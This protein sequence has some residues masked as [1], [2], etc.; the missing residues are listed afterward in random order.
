MQ[1]AIRAYEES[2]QYRTIASSLILG[3]SEIFVTSFKKFNVTLYKKIEFK[4][5]AHENF[6]LVCLKSILINKNTKR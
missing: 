6:T 2:I 4:V 5:K 3:K 1:R